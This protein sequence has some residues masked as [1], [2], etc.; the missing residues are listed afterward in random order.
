MQIPTFKV[1]VLGSA[2]ASIDVIKNDKTGK[3]FFDAGTVRGA[4]SSKGYDNPVISRVKGTDGQ[5]FLL[6]HSKGTTNV[7]DT[8]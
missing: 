1:N 2:D 3:L 8:L 6:L 4:V 7:V 5:E